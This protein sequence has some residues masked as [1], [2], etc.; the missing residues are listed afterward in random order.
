MLQVAVR[1]QF[2]KVGSVWERS[3]RRGS[4]VRSGQI[5]AYDDHLGMFLWG[6]EPATPGPLP[7]RVL[8]SAHLPT[9]HEQ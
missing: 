2:T 6:G 8:Q 9:S 5:P 3:N 7:L 1:D 4:L